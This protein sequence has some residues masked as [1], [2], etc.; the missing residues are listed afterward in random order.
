MSD[1][2]HLIQAF[3]AY[4][5]FGREAYF[6][7]RYNCIA[8]NL[9][10]YI[11]LKEGRE[12]M[13]KV[14][15]E[16]DFEKHVLKAVY[17]EWHTKDVSD[18]DQKDDYP[19]RYLFASDRHPLMIYLNLSGEEL[20]IEFYYDLAT[21]G[22][23]QWVLNT[24]HHLRQSFAEAKSPTFKILTR[25]ARKDAFYTKEVKTKDFKTLDIDRHYNDDFGKIG[26]IIS[27]AIGEESSGLILLHGAP[28]TGKTSYIKHLISK[29]PDKKFI[30]IQNE[31]VHELLKPSFISFLINR[32][33][34]ILIIEDAEKIM[35]PREA[36]G[37][38]SVVS[39]ILQ[40]TDGLFS[41]YLNIKVICTF[42]SSLRKVDKALLR[43]G[44]LI[45]NYEFLPLSV[46]KAN[47][48][49][50]SIDGEKTDKA[51]TLADIFN[52]DES[53]FE[54]DFQEKRLDFDK[55]IQ[56]SYSEKPYCLP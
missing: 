56:T 11:P 15:A 4:N 8:S 48:L 22:L 49:L 12:N 30:F 27:D 10:A 9:N 43:K 51:M 17:K 35:M 50:A 38:D 34:S 32:R 41:D 33:N 47:A 7:L 39:T 29:F 20:D 42:N 5:D 24:N 14:L 52:Q 36:S 19:Y 40:L 46:E 18:V 23:E 6:T 21:P 25:D 13:E 31:F 53:D 1:K 16:I 54:D 26:T 55:L 45:A 37:G 28:G 2:P 3:D 44:R